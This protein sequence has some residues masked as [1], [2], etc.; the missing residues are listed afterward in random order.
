MITFIS[1]FCLNGSLHVIDEEDLLNQHSTIPSSSFDNVISKDNMNI[2]SSL[3]ESITGSDDLNNNYLCD[4]NNS[5]LLAIDFDMSVESNNQSKNR[6]SHN[7]T[8]IMNISANTLSQYDTNNNDLSKNLEI[9]ANKIWEKHLH[10]PKIDNE[11]KNKSNKVDQIHA[12]TSHKFEELEKKKL[13]LEIREKE[14]KLQR[15]VERNAKKVDKEK[16]RIEREKK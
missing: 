5:M 3:V 2:S 14:L 4:K 10:Y 13:E 15:Q 9:D 6:I 1:F 8:E 12:I 11:S 16:T 7:N